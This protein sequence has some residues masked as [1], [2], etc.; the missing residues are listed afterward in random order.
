M[1]VRGL[2]VTDGSNL[3]RVGLLLLCLIGM[4][5]A[6]ERVHAAIAV[7]AGAMMLAFVLAFQVRLG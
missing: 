7:F 6:S 2:P 5:S 4:R 1:L 3:F